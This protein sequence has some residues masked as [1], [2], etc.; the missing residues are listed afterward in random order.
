MILEIYC[1]VTNESIS[2]CKQKTDFLYFTDPLNLIEV[3]KY[4]G[5]ITEMSGNKKTKWENSSG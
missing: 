5:N 2:V 3:P 4:V 1:S